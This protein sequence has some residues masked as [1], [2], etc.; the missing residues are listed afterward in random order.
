MAEK[1]K[2]RSRQSPAS[3]E[4]DEEVIRRKPDEAYIE[5]VVTPEDPEEYIDHVDEAPA[6]H[7]LVDSDLEDEDYPMTDADTE[8]AVDIGTQS[9]AVLDRVDEYTDDVEVLQDF[10]ERQAITAGSDQMMDRLREH[11]SLS[12]DL[13]GDDVDADWHKADQ[14]GEEAVGGTNPTPDQDQVAELGEAM[15]IEYE[16][17]EPLATEEKLQE[18]DQNRW[19]LDPASAEDFEEQVEETPAD[20]I[21]FTE[22]HEQ[23]IMD[24]ERRSVPMDHTT[25]KPPM[26]KSE[27]ADEKQLEMARSQGEQ[28]AKA[29]RHM[30]NQVAD[31]GG[32]EKGA[33]DYIV[34]YAI[35]DAEGLY[36]LENGELTWQE[37]EEANK[38]IE[39]SVRDAADNRF[40]PGLNVHVSLIDSQNR[41]VGGKRRLHFLWHPWLYHYGM[42]WKV[43]KSG[44]YTLR[45][46]IQAPDFMRHD[47]KNGRRY[48]D[49][50]EVTFENVTIEV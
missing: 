11:T 30:V 32:A 7:V 4:Q 41:E 14:S 15:G 31:D 6:D 23:M 39:I 27:E 42:N 8:D 25:K 24:M 35:E 49:D 37:P 44:D 21:D 16:P 20:T 50:V 17:G 47:E 1:D 45:V 12:P 33:G 5:P 26:E 38:H 22:D 43:P 10:E 48:A 9:D 46:Q 34:A 40:I 18:R 2:D 29:L 19:E 3:E 36:A 28:Y 13:S